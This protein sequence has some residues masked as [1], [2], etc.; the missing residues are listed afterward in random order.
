MNC[1]NCGNYIEDSTKPCPYC[2][3]INVEGNSI[4]QEYTTTAEDNQ[5]SFP[6]NNLNR[7]PLSK[8]QRIAIFIIIISTIALIAVLFVVFKPTIIKLGNTNN[9]NNTN[10]SS[11][12]V[13]TDDDENSDEEEIDDDY[14]EYD[15]EYDLEELKSDNSDV[16]DINEKDEETTKEYFEETAEKI[17]SITPVSEAKKVLSEKEIVKFLK[18]RGFNDLKV[19]FDYDMNGNYIKEQT[20]TN[21]TDTKHPCYNAYYISDTTGVWTIFIAQD[22]IVAYASQKTLELAEEGKIDAQI[23]LSESNDILSYDS[24]GNKYYL[25]IPKKTKID[26]RVVKKINKQTLDNYKFD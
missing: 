6:S 26:L 16:Y 22:K 25:T 3:E 13:V 11:N 9:I 20:I 12:T 5:S 17:I 24:L 2:G 19:E 14:L 4:N 18:D 1:K 15:E 10:S 7:V 21:P 23:I 8:Q